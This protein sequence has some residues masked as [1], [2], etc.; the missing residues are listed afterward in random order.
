MST[1]PSFFEPD[2]TRF[3]FRL[4]T[5]RVRP[6]HF[7]SQFLSLFESVP[8]TFPSQSVSFFEPD[9]YIFSSQSFPFYRFKTSYFLS[10]TFPFFRV[11][12][13]HFF[14]SNFPILFR[15]LLLNYFE[16][17]LQFLILIRRWLAWD[18]NKTFI[19]QWRNW[20]C[21]YAG[22]TYTEILEF[23]YLYHGYQIS[24]PKIWRNCGGSK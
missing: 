3:W 11:S 15:K 10:Q 16:F 1:R 22:F 12:P 21:F 17:I 7:S 23:L 18:V 8:L 13:S 5:F 19:F 20:Y 6:F 14:K 2:L 9:L 4:S 24:L